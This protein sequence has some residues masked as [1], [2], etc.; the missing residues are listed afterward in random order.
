L[1]FPSLDKIDLAEKLCHPSDEF[2]LKVNEI[3]QIVCP[4]R[5]GAYQAYKRNLRRPERIAMKFYGQDLWFIDQA[6]HS[7]FVASKMVGNKIL[8]K[9]GAGI[10]FTTDASQSAVHSSQQ[11]RYIL[12]CEIAIGD[13]W[14]IH[15]PMQNLTL[16]EV[17]SFGYDSVY[18][19]RNSEK[20]GG[21]QHDQFVIYHIHQALPLYLIS[22]EKVNKPT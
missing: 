12:L 14:T 21:V 16:A 3:F 9:Y 5:H 4:E 2:T 17:G 19:L 22:Y 1:N 15:C 11:D 10:Y 20:H 8:G 6:I 18:G 7:S 13:Y